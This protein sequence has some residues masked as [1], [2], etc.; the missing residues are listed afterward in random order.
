M[1]EAPH[2]RAVWEGFIDS[3][4]EQ[5]RGSPAKEALTTSLWI[6]D[7]NTMESSTVLLATRNILLMRSSSTEMNEVAIAAHTI[8]QC[9]ESTA[10][11][12]ET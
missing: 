9:D 3:H 1:D 11:S 5:S 7:V 10:T 4:V 6:F 8:K 2:A 12:N